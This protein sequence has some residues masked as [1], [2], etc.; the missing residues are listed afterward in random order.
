MAGFIRYR[1]NGS[2]FTSEVIFDV[3]ESEEEGRE[4]EV[5]DNPVEKGADVTDHVRHKPATVRITALV[6]NTPRDANV[7]AT[8]QPS[9][10]PPRFVLNTA[11]DEQR[12]GDDARATLLRIMEAGDTVELFLGTEKNGRSFP[13]MEMQSLSFP[14][15]A[16]T[17][18][19]VRFTASFKE[20]RIVESQSADLPTTAIPRNQ[21]PVDRGPQSPK[22]ASKK[23]SDAAGSGLHNMFGETVSSALNPGQ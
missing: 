23:D 2:E 1:P 20:V 7:A 12:P 21:A 8:Y 11:Q 14:R 16:K 10:S 22:P 4:N 18:E 13:S 19:T 6:S 15:D 3:V 17:G 5:T 9:A